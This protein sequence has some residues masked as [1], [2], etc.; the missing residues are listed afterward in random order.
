MEDHTFAEESW[1]CWDEHS[2][3]GRSVALEK[4]MAPVFTENSYFLTDP[5][6]SLTQ[7]LEL[8][9][10]E[11]NSAA[12]CYWDFEF[13][14]DE[15][16]ESEWHAYMFLFNEVYEIEEFGENS[17]WFYLNPTAEEKI[18]FIIT[19]EVEPPSATFWL[20]E[21]HVYVENQPR[22]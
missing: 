3:W 14:V 15:E 8:N 10:P 16:P 4:A 9:M 11:S 2:Y 21:I 19:Y 17:G 7:E 20:D 13:T 5:N 18:R 6:C 1:G 22:K 12:I